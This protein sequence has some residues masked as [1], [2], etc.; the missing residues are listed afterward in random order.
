MKVSDLKSSEELAHVV[1][2]GISPIATKE[3]TK[4]YEYVNNERTDRI[5]GYTTELVLT[6]QN[7]EKI[8]AITPSMPR[9][10]LGGTLAE[11]TQVELVNPIAEITWNNEIRLLAD[12]IVLS[13]DSEVIL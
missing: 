11:P 7:F 10:F 13:Q 5:K 4:L 6:N 12:D 1:L 3:P 2:E 9:V 8:R